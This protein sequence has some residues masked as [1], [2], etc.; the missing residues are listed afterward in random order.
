MVKINDRALHTYDFYKEKQADRRMKIGFKFN[1]NSENYHDVT[2]LLYKND[3][4]VE[5][6]EDKVVFSAVIGNYTTSITN[7]YKENNVGKFSLELI[8]KK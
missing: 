4:V 1:V 3:F 6:P 8:E 7:L 5:I 2:T